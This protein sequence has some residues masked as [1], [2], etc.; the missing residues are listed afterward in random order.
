MSVSSLADSENTEVSACSVVAEV[1]ANSFCDRGEER[2]ANGRIETQVGRE[3]P[4]EVREADAVEVLFHRVPPND[5]GPEQAIAV[6]I[7][8]S[9][10]VVGCTHF[11][12]ERWMPPIRVARCESLMEIRRCGVEFALVGPADDDVA[13]QC[14][15]ATRAKE[16]VCSAP[17]D[18]RVDPVP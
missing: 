9:P 2:L 15:P 8:W 6:L 16:V 3:R 7:R 14:E 1:G 18:R 13:E 10:A 11:L 4:K 17:S 5:R 12:F